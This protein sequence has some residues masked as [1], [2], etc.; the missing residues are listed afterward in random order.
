MDCL[1]KL[2]LDMLS[3]DQYDLAECIGVP[4]YAQLVRAYGGCNIYI[5]KR[6]VA[7]KAVRDALIRKE[8]D[9]S[10]MKQ[11]AR[12]YAVAT[13]TIRLIVSNK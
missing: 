6:D 10:N 5:G 11:L 3:K 8:F 12:K 9:G 4:A 1:D 2:T 13:N 7:E